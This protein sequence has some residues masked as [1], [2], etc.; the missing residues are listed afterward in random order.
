MIEPPRTA[1]LIV[2][3]KLVIFVCAYLDYGPTVYPLL[4]EDAL[5]ALFYHLCRRLYPYC[6]LTNVYCLHPW[7]RSQ[8]PRCSRNKL[9]H[10]H[11][12]IK[13]DGL[14]LLLPQKNPALTCSAA[15]L[16]TPFR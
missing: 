16:H 5:R 10:V 11:V 9:W 4:H 2:L 12:S 6:C 3:N 7:P 15:F 13:H 1:G 14:S 8:R